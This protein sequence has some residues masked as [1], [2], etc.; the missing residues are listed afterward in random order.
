MFA[1]T[2]CGSDKPSGSNMGSASGSTPGGLK[3]ILLLENGHSPFWDAAQAGIKDA[4]KELKL[5]GAGLVGSLETNDG[6]P[7]G[8]IDKLRQFASQSDIAGIAISVTDADNVAIAEELR[9][10]QEK[11]VKVVTVDSD[12]N[13]NK[14]R[15]ARFAF[16]GTDNLAGGREL[17]K[18]ALGIR[19][20]GGEWV[21]FVGR[22]GAQNAIERVDGFA[23]G[24][25][26][27]FKK[28]DNMAD[29]I[30]RT[31]ARENVRNAIRNHPTV[32]TLV[33]IWSYNAPAIADVVKEMNKRSNMTIV[34]F[35]AEPLAMKAMEDGTI[36]AL[37]VQNPYRMGYDS[38]RMLKALIKKDDATIKEMLPQ[39]GQPNGDLYDT[40]LKV[41]VPDQG[42]PLNPSMFDKN[43][44]FLKLG[45]FRKWLAKYNLSES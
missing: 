16:V 18:C 9:K 35:D 36:D 34:A 20:D 11:G 37:I 7:K 44:Q 22:T 24:A 3:R 32:N 40:G 10:F 4:N 29:D 5:E 30:D 15:D 43:T 45:E 31:R 1:I 42:S 27:K 21:S 25:G 17:G 19:P 39:H 6:T 14:L 12:L 33:G 38:M 13:R 23:E 8:Q 41:I 28:L 26:P 2:G